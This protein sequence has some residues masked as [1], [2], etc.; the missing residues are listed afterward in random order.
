MAKSNE[1]K[2]WKNFA[3][4]NWEKKAILV[5]N[6]ESSLSEINEE[7]I[8]MML[9]SYSNQCRKTTSA[10]GFKFYVHGQRQ[11][12][13]EILQILPLEKDRSLL[14]YHSR[15]EKIFSDYCLV[16]DE[17]LQVS[18]DNWG[19]LCAFTDKL[20]SYVGFPNRFSELGLYLGNYR[21]TPFGVHVDGCG[22]FSFPVVGQKKFRLWTS[23]FVKKNP[24][25]NR[26]DHYS[27]FKKNS[28]VFNAKPGDMTYWPSSAWHIAESDG[29][30]SATWSL[31]V[32]LDRSHQETVEDA[33]KPLLKS[34]LGSLGE[35]CVTN[36]KPAQK[37]GQVLELPLHQLKSISVIRKLSKNAL[38]DT[39]MKS[40][41]ELRS[42]QGLAKAP[43]LKIKKNISLHS[44]IQ[45]L[46]SNCIFWTKLKSEPKTI[47][48]FQGNLVETSPAPELLKL[49]KDLNSGKTCIVA[50]Y[51]K[52]PHRQRDLSA[53]RLLGQAGAFQSFLKKLI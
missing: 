43:E 2:F 45:Q 37:N 38:H 17:L 51:L 30:F 53:L 39:F 13:E 42:K 9:V 35:D 40:W 27:Q 5:R 48:A 31:G 16:C 41:I 15:M 29:S 19:K 7:Q 20:F 47:Y 49:I 52:G 23:A 28:V 46:D 11:H 18:Q 44:R 36:P 33:L 6:F 22:V 50:D 26:A 21:K 3:K 1:Q 24:K 10:R 25:L 14:G 4:F 12:E 32:W 34:Q 8:F